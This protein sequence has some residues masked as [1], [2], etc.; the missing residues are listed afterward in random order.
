MPKKLVIVESPAKARTIGRYLGDDYVVEASVGHIR[1]L[2]VNRK[3]LPKELQKKWWAD[4]AVDVDDGFKPIY[5]VPEDKQRHVE[6]LKSAMKGVSELVLATDEDREGESISWH[7]LQVLQPPKDLPIRRIAFHEITRQAIQEALENPRPID[8]RLVEAQE[9]RRILDRLYGYAL[10]PVLWYRLTKQLSAGR[11]Q[12]PAVKLI[13]EREKRRRDFRVSVY[14]D[15]KAELAADGKSFEAILKTLDGR[16]LASGQDFDEQTGTLKNDRALL[17]QEE[18]AASLSEQGRDAAPWTVKM[19]EKKPGQEKPPAPFRTTTLQQDANRKFGFSAERTMRVAQDL[20]EGVEVRGESVGLITYMRTD[21]LTLSEEAIRHIRDEI[22]RRFSKDDLPAKPV[23]YES[24]VANAQEAHEAVRPTDMSLTPEGI[25]S[26]LESRSPDHYK[27]YDL[28]YER[29]LACQMKPAEVMRTQVEV[30]VT[31]QGQ[32]LVFGASGKE[33]VYPGFLKAYVE[34]G[35]DPDAALEGRERILPELKEG[36]TLDL[37]DLQADR[38]ET[39]L[40]ARY[41]EASL[42]KALEERGIGRPSTYATILSVIVDRGYVRRRGKELVPTFVAFLAMDV[43]EKH[44]EE[45]LDLGFTAQMDETLDQIAS[46]KGDSREYLRKFFLGG[47]GR[48]GLK[49]AVKERLPEIPYPAY[50]VGKHP[51]TD[52]P[53]W[54]RIGQNMDA[55]LQLGDK[56]KKVFASIPE[57]VAPAE[58]NVERSVE[59]LAAR[60]PEAEA[61]G[62]HP[63]TGRKLLLRQR[64]GFYLEVER[65]PEEIESKVKP[66]WVSVPPGADPREMSQEELDLLCELP[67]EIGKHPDSGEAIVFRL[68]R[69]GP[70][71]QCGS[72]FRNIEDWREGCRMSLEEALALLA[73][74]KEGR[75]ARKPTAPIHEFG[76]LEGAEGPVRVLSGRFGP[77]VTDGVTN[78]TLPRNLDPA[79]VTAEQARELLLKKK[80]AGPSPKKRF[81][82]KR[83]GSKK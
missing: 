60:K 46:G 2:P 57:D 45:F 80:A 38:H 5:V 77:Y 19:V 3:G 61:V 21:S 64:Q 31:I 32:S 8:A 9:A 47:N 66:T 79:Q 1:D 72:E 59:L 17:L 11:V 42:I 74:P 70:V 49:E 81:T 76:Q 4:Y 48:P 83:A 65:T 15:L 82:R 40:P 54:V 34:E 7:L 41:T 14:W 33:I 53:I 26:A 20:Y 12:S 36:Q 68:A 22:A 55:F 73:Q 27:L 37:K 52:E 13:V 71:L 30:A 18:S 75:G 69:S 58:L 28:I 67:R 51:E 16:P 50:E 63:A 29:T 43:L 62:T 44:F 23:R 39:R 25:R 10:S 6:R 24:K 35:D 56:E 78:A